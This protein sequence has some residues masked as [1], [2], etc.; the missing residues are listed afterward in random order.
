MEAEHEFV[1]RGTVPNRY[2]QHAGR[3]L[4]TGYWGSRLSRNAMETRIDRV[5][6]GGF[7]K[8]VG[9]DPHALLRGIHV[10]EESKD[11]IAIGGSG[12]KGIVL[13]KIVALFPRQVATFFFDSPETRVIQFPGGRVVRQEFACKA[14][15]GLREVAE[16]VPNTLDDLR[17]G[18]SQPGYF[19]LTGTIRDIFV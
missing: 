8:W 5:L 17:T 16:A 19:L 4:Q 15:R 7:L 3:T 9:R 12:G 11:Q 18:F 14:R 6:P 10:D 2:S 13:K 1:V